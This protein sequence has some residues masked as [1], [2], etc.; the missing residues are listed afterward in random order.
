MHDYA[1]HAS[2]NPALHGMHGTPHARIHVRLAA[3]EQSGNTFAVPS[4][5]AH[6]L[7]KKALM[8]ILGSW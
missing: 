4:Q 2:Q 6:F 7:P 5:D 8:P 1:G 3:F